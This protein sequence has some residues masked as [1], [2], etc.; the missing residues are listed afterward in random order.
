M[1]AIEKSILAFFNF[2][3]LEKQF[4]SVRKPDSAVAIELRRKMSKKAVFGK[5]I[6]MYCIAQKEELI[7]KIIAKLVNIEIAEKWQNLDSERIL[8]SKIHE[9]WVYRI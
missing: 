9:K 7:A 5:K 6:Q 8:A 4:F 3:T 2:K 1:I